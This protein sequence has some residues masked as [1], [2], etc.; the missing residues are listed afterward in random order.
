MILE[1]C[2]IA[3]LVT[4]AIS[5]AFGVAEIANGV[6]EIATAKKENIVEAEDLETKSG[7]NKETAEEMADLYNT[8]AHEL[9]K[10]VGIIGVLGGGVSVASGLEGVVL[11]TIFRNK[12]ATKTMLK[13][14]YGTLGVMIFTTIIDIITQIQKIKEKRNAK[15]NARRNK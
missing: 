2:A 4:G 3:S 14:A 12:N 8:Q 13:F 6:H 15:K 11:Y 5:A 1:I 10:R 9:K 7:I